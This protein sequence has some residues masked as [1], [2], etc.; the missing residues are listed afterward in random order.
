MFEVATQL[1]FDDTRADSINLN[2]DDS[3]RNSSDISNIESFDKDIFESSPKHLSMDVNE[4]KI[5]LNL[6]SLG[7]KL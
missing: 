7:K 1:D 2:F 5:L 6:L 4:V 3:S